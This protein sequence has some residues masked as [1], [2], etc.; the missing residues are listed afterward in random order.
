[1]KKAP[2]RS[3]ALLILLSYI[4]FRQAGDPLVWRSLPV[5]ASY[6]FEILFVAGVISVFRHRLQWRYRPDLRDLGALVCALASGAVVY[7]G[8]RPLDVPIPFDLTSTETLVLLL[9]VAPLLEEA[10]FRLALWE[11]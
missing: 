5:A 10:L 6:A 4:V 2:S 8:A 7:R 11:P 1:M 3:Q 9:L